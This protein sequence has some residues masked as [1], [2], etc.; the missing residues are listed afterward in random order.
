MIN[1]I[2]G[3]E[4]RI[5]RILP[6]ALKHK[7]KL[8]ALTMGESGMPNTA[9]ERRD[10]ARHILERLKKDG[11]DA[12]NLYF[13]PL[14]RP[15]S[16]EPGQAGEFL[17]SIPLIK[18]LGPVKVIC[19]LSNV[20]YGLPNRKTINSVFLSMAIHAGLDAAILDPTDKTMIASLR[21]SE[22]LLGMDE[23]CAGYIKSFREGKLA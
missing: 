19:G 9:E 10:I 22:A 13:D 2:T 6:L 14:I 21:S 23:Y 3:E 20:S 16:T 4:G 17:R 7:A 5:G 15:V 18:S 1:S 12:A 11:F 8:V